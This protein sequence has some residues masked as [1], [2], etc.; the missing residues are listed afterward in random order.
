MPNGNCG[1]AVDRPWSGRGEANPGAKLAGSADAVLGRRWRRSVTRASRPSSARPSRG[2][3]SLAHG[4]ASLVLLGSLAACNTSQR[5]SGSGGTTSTGGTLSTGGTASSGGTTSTGGT[6]SSGGTQGSGGATSPGGTASRGGSG[7]S[8]GMPASGGTA[9]GGTTKSG[10]STG[11]GGDS[12]AGGAAAE[13]GAPAGGGSS[14]SGGASGRGGATAA[15]GATSSGGATSAG[16]TPGGGGELG[17]GGATG[18]GGAG[19]AP[20]F[21]DDF[22]AD[23][24]GKGPAGFDAFIAYN[25]NGQNPSGTTLALVDS[26]RAHSGTKSVHVHGGQQ[27]AQIGKTLPTG[28]TRLYMRAFVYMTRQLGVHDPNTANHE[29]LFVLRK[30]PNGADNEVRFGEIKGTLGT[31]EVPTDD[32]SPVDTEW[33]KGQIIPAGDWICIEVAFLGDLPQHQLLAYANGT[34]VHSVTAPDQ[35]EHKTAGATFL[36]GKFVQAVFGWQ[37][38]SNVDTDLWIDD[39]ALSSAPIGCGS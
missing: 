34:L 24:T 17:N 16:G 30:N 28:L 7:G 26:T 3:A 37:S 21:T 2:R 32:I 31:N 10:G 5:S 25:L 22:E 1:P 9:S 23:A 11:S 19:Q 12:G 15:G 38:F 14:S 33:G 4:L 39:V 6:T 29:S 35:W 13:G 27:P 8:G 20:F 36:S 18:A